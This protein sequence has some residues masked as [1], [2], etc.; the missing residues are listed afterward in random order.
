M[1]PG[2]TIGLDIGTT[3]VKA[4][5]LD[6]AGHEAGRATRRL[7]M[8]TSSPGMAQ[9]DPYE[10]YRAVTDVM[11]D[12]A[13]RVT[14]GGLH[15]ERVGF[16][17]AMHSLIPISMDAT[18]LMPALT[19]MDIRAGDDAN[20]LWASAAG[21]E[22][23]R[24]TGTPVHAMSPLVKLGWLQ[25]TAPETMRQARRFVSLKEWIW[26]QWFGTWTIDQSM[27]SATGLYDLETGHWNEQACALVGI[28]TASLSNIV[29]TS[30]VTT[31]IKDSQLQSYYG[32]HVVFNIG[33][34]DGVLAN[35][36][37]GVVD[38]SQMVMTIG[39]SLAIR[40][41]SNQIFT[42]ESIRPFCYV[43]DD[44]HYIVGGPSNSGGIVLDWLYHHVLESSRSGQQCKTLDELCAQ[45]GDIEI[46]DLVCLPY[47]A[48]ERAPL[49]DEN[50]TGAFIGLRVHHRDVHLVRAAIEGIIYNA[51]AVASSLFEKL[52]EPFTLVV[53]GHLFDFVW[54]RQL[55]ADVFRIPVRFEPDGDASI[56]GAIRL[57]NHVCQVGFAGEEHDTLTALVNTPNPELSY[58]AKRLRF[59]R[60]SKMILTNDSAQ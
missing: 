9:Q 23:Y 33:G 51:H 47:I 58:D 24:R 1:K 19:W 14:T 32:P 54:V 57:V 11:Q 16:S 36:G 29:P 20:R 26:F 56:R 37:L 50:A 55:I 8:L 52:G 10:V 31:G 4:V 12:V 3:S 53:S 15:I 42:D 22:L 59:Q 18:P 30:F 48:G 13:H 40:T 46:D 39:T 34:S 28:D 43:L 41:G 25:R 44:T 7:A 45:A 17:A 5:A 21:R 2:C 6:S 35:Y 49:W 27:A 60:L 38:N